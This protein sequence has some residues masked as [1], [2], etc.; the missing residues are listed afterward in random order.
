MAGEPVTLTLAAGDSLIQWLLLPRLAAIRAKLPGVTFRILNLPTTEIAARLR[1]GTVDLALVR[2]GSVARPLKTAA[3][4]MMSFSLF[5]P[6][7]MPPA[8]E[9]KPAL[10]DAWHALPLA[11]LEGSGQFR[12]ELRRGA[13]RHKLKLNFQ[14]ELSSFPLVARV[15]ATGEYAAIL[16]SLAAVELA[17]SGAVESRPDFLRPFGRK[18]VVAW[19]PRLTSIRAALAK[20]IPVFSGSCRIESGD[21]ASHKR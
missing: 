21:G 1:D 17:R 5:V 16:P 8:A 14:L 19:N 11:T 6:A 4:G 3:L 12:Q 15:V 10:A 7:S 20:A 2:S 13:E 18:I 9:R